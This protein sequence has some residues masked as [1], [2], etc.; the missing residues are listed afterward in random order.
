[1][2]QC[3]FLRFAGCVDRLVGNA[4]R[5]PKPSGSGQQTKTRGFGVRATGNP[6]RML[7]S[8]K[9]RATPRVLGENPETRRAQATSPKHSWRKPFAAA[10][11]ASDPTSARGEPGN[12]HSDPTS[13][14]GEPGNSQGASDL[15]LQRRRGRLT[16]PPRSATCAT[17]RRAE[18][19]PHCPAASARPPRST[20]NR[21]CPR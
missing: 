19:T 11:G 15:L 8:P 17:S 7:P 13:A 4:E 9:V 3:S 2:L 14:R 16:A 21:R 6:R 20:S 18:S 12:P 5:P 1:M 10:A